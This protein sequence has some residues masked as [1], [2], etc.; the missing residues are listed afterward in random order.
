MPKGFQKGNRLGAKAAIARE[1]NKENWWAFVASGGV[2]RYKELYE[3]LGRG[4]EINKWEQQF[5]D[6]TETNFP[7]IKSRKT[8]VTTDGEKIEGS[9]ITF[10]NADDK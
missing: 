10:V 9:L 2:R 8:D 4:E 1:E 6:R 7:Y 5:M 3:Q